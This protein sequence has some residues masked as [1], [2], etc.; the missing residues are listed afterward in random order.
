MKA[1]F[2]VPDPAAI[3]REG[4]V[5]VDLHFHTN[6]SDSFTDP[7]RA[8]RL[9]EKRGLGF[10]VTDHNLISS[11]IR[12]YGED[13]SVPLIPGMEVSTTDGPHVLV[14]FYTMRDLERFWYSRIRPRIQENPWLALRDCPTS[15]LLDFCEKESCVVSAAHPAGYFNTNK[16]VEICVR[17]G[18]VDP[19]VRERL[20]AYEVISG[21]MTRLSNLTALRAAE[22]LG[23]G[24]TGGSDAHVMSDLGGVVTVV[25][26]ETVEGILEDIRHRRTTVIGS[27]KDIK[28]KVLTGQA[29]ARRFAEHAP[30]TVSMK[31]REVV[32]R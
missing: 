31:A 29:S 5:P 32:K 3:R 25:E 9:A 8:L 2:E 14:Y 6:C 21:G 28:D 18:I 11:L 26:S 24:F 23:L 4:L 16:G 10:A 7:F 19:R 1:V 15:K 12:I 17:K 27:E 13:R 30:S 20:D 22:T